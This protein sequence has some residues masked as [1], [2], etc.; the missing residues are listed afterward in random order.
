MP[1][2]YQ[3]TLTEIINELSYAGF[4]E[5]F[6]AKETYF[7]GVST[8]KAYQ[9]EKMKIMGTYRFD[10]SA[11]EAQKSILYAIQTSDGTKGTLVMMN[12]ENQEKNSMLIDRLN[13]HS[14]AEFFQI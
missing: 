11:D 9:P 4:N 12:I 7:Q 2:T 13:E 3:Q 14:R 1:H 8:K 5:S 10:E 6:I